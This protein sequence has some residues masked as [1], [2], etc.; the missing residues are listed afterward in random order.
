MYNSTIKDFHNEVEN[1]WNQIK[2]EYDSD[3]LV[4]LD[5]ILEY[6]ENGEVSKFIQTDTR[7]KPISLMN[8]NIENRY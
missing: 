8:L 1:K 7:N 4:G 5:C 2:K 6:N 3:N